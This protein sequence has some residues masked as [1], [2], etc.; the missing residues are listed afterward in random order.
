LPDDSEWFVYVLVSER[1]E[2]TYVGIALD[3]DKRLEEHNGIR[4]GGA[5]STRAHR[6]WKLAT[7]YGPFANRSE[8]CVAEARV[9]KLKGRQRLSWQMAVWLLLCL[10]LAPNPVSAQEPERQR[11]TSTYFQWRAPNGNA[12]LAAKLSLEADQI[13][14]EA[15]RWLGLQDVGEIGP[16][17]RPGKMIWVSNR[18]GINRHLKREMPT[19]V[20]AVAIPSRSEI[21]ISLQS[22]GELYRL[23]STLRHELLHHAI[24]SLGADAFQRLPAWFHEGLAEEFSGEIYLADSGLSL[25]WMAMSGHLRYLSDFEHDFGRAGMRAAEGYAQGHAFVQMLRHDFGAMVVPRILQAVH[26]GMNFERAVLESTGKPMVELEERMR[27]QL[28]SFRR[29]AQDFYQHFITVLF[30]LA[31]L[32]LPF[33]WLRRKRRRQRMEQ[34]W[35]QQEEDS[36]LAE[37]SQAYL[38][39][40]TERDD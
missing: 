6:P 29:M 13:L 19:W 26:Q 28:T 30:A 27:S 40:I 9:K 21:V 36:K 17:P 1:I 34:K 11:G 10:L 15:H 5:R 16:T 2:R 39:D 24:G 33:I 7:T 12:E 38:I 35:E 8:A 32:L 22:A 18:D 23:R 20:A 3:P 31:C 14:E 4:T 25:S 37:H